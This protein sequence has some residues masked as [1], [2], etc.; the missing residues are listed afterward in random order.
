MHPT[1]TY[2]A[3]ILLF[4]LEEIHEILHM[5]SGTYI[6]L[7]V[8]AMITSTW[9]RN[10]V[11][12]IGACMFEWMFELHFIIIG[13]NFEFCISWMPR[14]AHSTNIYTL[15]FG[16]EKFTLTF[17]AFVIVPP[18]LR[19]FPTLLVVQSQKLSTPFKKRD[20]KGLQPNKLRG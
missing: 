8:C 1:P 10:R 15:W 20:H 11:R 13:K 9:I 17:P 4:S 14:N 2:S 5:S 18:F 19:F 12:C 6:C 7:Y 3:C 16:H